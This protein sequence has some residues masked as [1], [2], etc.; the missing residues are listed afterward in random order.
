MRKAYSTFVF[1][2][3]NKYNT[4]ILSKKYQF[5]R[6]LEV[7]EEVSYVRRGGVVKDMDARSQAVADVKAALLRS[8]LSTLGTMTSPLKGRA[9]NVEFLLWCR[10][11][12]GTEN[13]ENR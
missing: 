3:L 10:P 1:F 7:P 9:G 13:E 12:V 11:G 6:E 8:G 4:K 5:L 2:Q